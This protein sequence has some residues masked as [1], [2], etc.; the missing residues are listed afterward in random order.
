MKAESWKFPFS[1]KGNVM[2]VENS[3]LSEIARLFVRLDHV[4]R[5]VVKTRPKVNRFPEA[6]LPRQTCKIL[7]KTMRIMKTPRSI[8]LF[9]AL[10][11]LALTLVSCASGPETTTTTTSQSAVPAATPS[12]AP[13]RPTMGGYSGGGH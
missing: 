10:S 5:F 12:L 9:S 7:G 8:I 3:P 13:M 4:A 6:D 11:I 2:R 1:S